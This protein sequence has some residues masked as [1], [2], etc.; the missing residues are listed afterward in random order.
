MADRFGIKDAN[1]G[2]IKVVENVFQIVCSLGM[3]DRYLRRVSPE[4][5]F[6]P[7][8]WAN[9]PDIQGATNNLRIVLVTLSQ[10]QSLSSR[11]SAI[12]IRSGLHQKN[13][14]C[15]ADGRRKFYAY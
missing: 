9:T 4:C 12:E 6:W 11:L 8:E 10:A 14:E 3:P 15:A 7:P 13:D 2:Q 1:K 5:R